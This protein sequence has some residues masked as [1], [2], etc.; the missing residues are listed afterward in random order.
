MAL[1]GTLLK[2]SMIGGV[3]LLGAWGVQKV[4]K[5]RKP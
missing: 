5:A 1:M 2:W 4:V 3:V